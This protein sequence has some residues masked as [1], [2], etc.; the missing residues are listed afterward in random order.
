M[1]DGIRRAAA[2][3]SPLPSDPASDEYLKLEKASDVY[4]VSAQK[5]VKLTDLWNAENDERCVF[6]W[7][8]SMG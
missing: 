8:R 1:E 7:G 2:S 4:L 6:V 3:S 5:E